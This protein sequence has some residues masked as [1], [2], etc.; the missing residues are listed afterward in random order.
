MEEVV[1]D[2]IQLLLGSRYGAGGATDISLYGTSNSTKWNFDDHL[3]SRVIVAGGGG[4]AS[5]Y[6]TF[7]A[8][9]TGGGN[10]GT[11]GNY[12]SNTRG[13]QIGTDTNTTFSSGQ[14]FGIGG[15]HTGNAS[16]RWWWRLVS[17][18]LLAVMQ[19]IILEEVVVLDGYIQNQHIIIGKIILRKVKVVNGN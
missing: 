14:G 4:G 11:D 9:G 12:Q 18:V 16:S 6:G 17:V 1:L 10:E 8:P 13:T 3:Y 15:S 2:K 5:Y 7:Y 19:V